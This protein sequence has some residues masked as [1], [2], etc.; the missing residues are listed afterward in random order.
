VYRIDPA[1]STGRGSKI[2]VSTIAGGVAVFIVAVAPVLAGQGSPPRYI[3]FLARPSCCI[4]GHSFVQIGTVRR[5]GTG[6]ADKTIGL[7][8]ARYPRSDRAA[9]IDAP[10]KIMRTT[11]DTRESATARYRVGVSEHTYR[12]ALAHA[13][14]MTAEWR[15]YDLATENCNKVLFEFAERLGL[16]VSRDM[17]ELPANIVRGMEQS[18]DGRSRASW[19]P[20]G[21][22]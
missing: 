15:R 9:L 21:G 14:R 22:W 13:R 5:D 6:R 10:G 16:D 12:K 17:L 18:N 2:G 7:Y 1:A 4:V 3:E 19:R 20:T 11:A 8:P